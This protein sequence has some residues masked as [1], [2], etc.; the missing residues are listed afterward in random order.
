V[1]DIGE[2]KAFVDDD[3]GGVLVGGGVGGA[4]VRVP[5]PTNMG[6]AALLLVI[7][8]LL[9]PSSL[10]VFAPVIV[11]RNK[12]FC[13]KVTGLTTLVANF[14]GAGLVV[15]SPPL[16]EDLAKAFDY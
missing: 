7:L 6:I 4:L 15:L 8:L 10:L 1:A 13:Y 16:L 2:E 12:T 14:L 11:T 5:F 3:V 9:L